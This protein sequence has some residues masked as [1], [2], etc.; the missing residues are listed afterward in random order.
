LCKLK[1]VDKILRL[2]NVRYLHWFDR[3]TS[4]LQIDHFKC[5][6][7][8]VCPNIHKEYLVKEKY[9]EFVSV[10][11]NRFKVHQIKKILSKQQIFVNDLN[12]IFGILKENLSNIVSWGDYYSHFMGFRLD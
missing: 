1:E 9:L 12:K 8:L 3:K 11:E 4:E 5:C 6:K 10:K 7:S 2:C